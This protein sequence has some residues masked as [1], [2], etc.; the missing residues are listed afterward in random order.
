MPP[1]AAAVATVSAS[2]SAADTIAAEAA[3]P[4]PDREQRDRRRR[5]AQRIAAETKKREQ[6]AAKAMRAA[7]VQKTDMSEKQRREMLLKVLQ[8]PLA[9]QT[10]AARAAAA[11][12]CRLIELPK[13][14]PF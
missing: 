8:A 3:P 4:S 13:L 14:V 5:V 6:L 10:P 9:T 2:A 12:S 11:T 7:Q 1:L